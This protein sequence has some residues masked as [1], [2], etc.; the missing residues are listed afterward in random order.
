MFRFSMF[1]LDQNDRGQS[2]VAS[3]VTSSAKRRGVTLV[4]REQTTFL[5]LGRML[6]VNISESVANTGSS[7][8]QSHSLCYKSQTSGL[9]AYHFKCIMA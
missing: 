9:D 2:N 7:D 1:E 6:S 3:R 8:P 4:S 5:T